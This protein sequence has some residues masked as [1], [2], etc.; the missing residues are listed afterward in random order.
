MDR[1]IEPYH[2]MTY[3][4]IGINYKQV[5]VANRGI[6]HLSLEQ[7]QELFQKAR[8]HSV[9]D[10]YI[11]ATCNRTEI[12]ALCQRP[13]DLL[14]LLFLV[15]DAKYRKDFED[16]GY[17]KRGKDAV[18]HLF[19]VSAGL[20]SQILGD[21]EIV[22]QVKTAF[23]QAKNWG[24]IYSS[25]GERVL[26]MALEGAK[27]VRTNTDISSGTL[28]VSMA[29]VQSIVKE[30]PINYQ[31]KRILLVG[32]GDIGKNIYGYLQ[33]FGIKQIKVVNRSPEKVSIIY[34]EAQVYNLS[35][36]TKLLPEADIIITATAS[37]EP[38][39]KLG[40]LSENQQYLLIDL[41][42]PANIEQTLANLKGIKLKQLDEISRILDATKQKRY[43][44]L[45]KAEAILQEH[46]DEFLV[47]VH[48]RKQMSLLKGIKARLLALDKKKDAQ[49]HINELALSFRKQQ[50]FKGCSVIA[51]YQRYLYGVSQ[52][53]K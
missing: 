13:S 10:L 52:D 31:E 53:G 8:Y 46:L 27:K 45:P 48:E 50:S 24:C 37:K 11:L 3:T 39:L 23:Q 18:L 17:L 4:V 20:D 34:P 22:G 40:M 21:Y 2:Q 16:L 15:L 44:E 19:R 49:K 38:L 25:F 7:I 12:Y 9:S 33:D 35:L 47:W 5:N 42:L 41:S 14:D 1:A 6:Y 32:F 30:Y 51:T 26:N 36:L 43:E 28:S 29:A